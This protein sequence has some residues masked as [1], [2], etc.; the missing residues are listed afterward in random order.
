MNDNPPEFPQLWYEVVVSESVAVGETILTP[1]ATSKD[2]G[3]NAHLTYEIVKGNEQRNLAI[4]PKT[5]IYKT[6]KS[7]CTSK[8]N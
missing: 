8:C 7:F 2:E 6:L 4:N 5:G 1:T 3:E